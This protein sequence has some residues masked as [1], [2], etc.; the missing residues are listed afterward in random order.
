M[1]HT[2]KEGHKSKII[3]G[4][5]IFWLGVF[6][7]AIAL[8]SVFNQSD[9][10]PAV[11]DWATWDGEGEVPSAKVIVVNGEVTRNGYVS[12]LGEIHGLAHN[13]SGQTLSYIQVVYG[14]Y[15]EGGIKLGNCVANQ[16]YL[17]N[18]TSWE[19]DAICTNLPDSSFK[20]RVDDVT[21][22]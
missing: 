7:L 6:L 16:N 18:N 22:W 8:I 9:P 5:A 4:K 1:A 15:D 3:G 20:Y 13:R 21:Y 12:S 10:A 17:A 19:Y 14:V 11:R 2:K